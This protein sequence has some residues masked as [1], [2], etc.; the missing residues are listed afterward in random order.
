MNQSRALTDG[1]KVYPAIFYTMYVQKKRR[2]I[3]PAKII[4]D[5]SDSTFLNN[6]GASANSLA[7]AVPASV[8]R[9]I[10]AKFANVWN[11][12]NLPSGP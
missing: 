12:T 8:P 9:H 5:H 4:G 10:T 6:D 11:P 3:M 1:V 7:I 2:T